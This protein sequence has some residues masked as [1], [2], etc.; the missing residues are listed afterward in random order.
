MIF[1]TEQLC[2]SADKQNPYESARSRSTS[3]GSGS[4]STL[5]ARNKSHSSL[6]E[7]PDYEYPTPIFVRNTFIDTPIVRPASLDEFIQ[8]RRIHSCPTGSVDIAGQESPK[9]CHMQESYFHTS[10]TSLVDAA[11]DAKAIAARAISSF[12]TWWN[13]IVS[14]SEQAPELDYTLER[15]KGNDFTDHGASQVICLANA[16]V[17]PELGSPEFPTVGSAG[18]RWGTCKPCA[19]LHKRG[20]ENGTQCD[21]CHLC[22]SGEKKRRQKDKIARLK[23]MRA[24]ASVIRL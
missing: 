19:F 4:G 15:Q 16:L 20:C 1:Q 21:F 9:K 12:S 6:C 10:T 8:E 13:P 23:E 17:E 11:N 2:D 14:S 18:H 22:D 3:A 24:I 5:D 7:L